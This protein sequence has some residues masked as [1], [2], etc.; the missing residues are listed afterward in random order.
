MTLRFID[1]PHWYRDLHLFYALITQEDDQYLAV[2]KYIDAMQ[3][4]KDEIERRFA[5]MWATSRDPTT[6]FED[7]IAALCMDVMQH[8]L[9]GDQWTQE[10]YDVTIAK[11]LAYLIDIAVKHPN[12]RE[13][14]TADDVKH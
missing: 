10:N 2:A 12:L 7:I 13:P 1:K 14:P 11:V 6:V 3:L 8:E 9:P 4:P 5:R